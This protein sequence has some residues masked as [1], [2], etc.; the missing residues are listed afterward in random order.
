[1]I[2]TTANDQ[3]AAAVYHERE[4]VVVDASPPVEVVH[5]EIW[6]H[7]AARLRARGYTLRDEGGA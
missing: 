1:M 4:G 3:P 7:V 6:R 2:A 5:A